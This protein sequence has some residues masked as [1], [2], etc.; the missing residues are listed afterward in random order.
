MKYHEVGYERRSAEIRY[1]AR[2]IETGEGRVM[3]MTHMSVVS[4][5]CEFPLHGLPFDTE[6]PAVVAG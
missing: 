3:V 4:S 1:G 2:P 6:Y 5:C